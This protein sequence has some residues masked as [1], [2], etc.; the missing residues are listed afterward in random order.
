MHFAFIVGITD[1]GKSRNT[2]A[3]TDCTESRAGCDLRCFLIKVHPARCVFGQVVWGGEKPRDQE[4]S[5]GGGTFFD[6][7]KRPLSL[8][9]PGGCGSFRK[10][11]MGIGAKSR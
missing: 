5:A 8:G 9:V 10:L 3:N 4:F 6:G 1:E 7:A 2:E 11:P